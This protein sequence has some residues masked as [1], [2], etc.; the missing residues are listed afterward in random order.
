MG[1]TYVAKRGTSDASTAPIPAPM[2]KC[3]PVKW[4]MELA[5]GTWMD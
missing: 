5:R 1:K 3:G 4:M 2:Q